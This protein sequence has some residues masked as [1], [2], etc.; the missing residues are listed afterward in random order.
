MTR[1]RDNSRE[2]EYFVA[3]LYST[4]FRMIL[5]TTSNADDIFRVKRVS[6]GSN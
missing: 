3:I 1:V 2:I 6:F 5:R 4:A